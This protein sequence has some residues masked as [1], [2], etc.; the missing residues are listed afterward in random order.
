[1]RNSITRVLSAVLACVLTLNLLPAGAVDMSDLSLPERQSQ[2]GEAASIAETNVETPPLETGILQIATSETEPATSGVT[3]PTGNITWNIDTE[4]KTFTLTGSGPMTDFGYGSANYKDVPWYDFFYANRY[5]GNKDAYSIVIGEGITEIYDLSC[6]YI[7]DVSFPSTLTTIGDYCF[8][9]LG[10]YAGSPAI[11]LPESVT[12]VGEY[13]FH[14]LANVT[15]ITIPN[16]DAQLGKYCFNNCFDLTELVLPTN[17]TTIPEGMA[18]NCYWMTEI[19]I[20]A[21]VTS[22]GASAFRSCNRLTEAILPEGLVELGDNAFTSCYSLTNV[23]QLPDTL[24]TIGRAAFGSCAALTSVGDFPDSLKTIGDSAF[25]GCTALTHFNF[26]PAMADGGS[27]GERAFYQ[28]SSLSGHLTVPDG[29]TLGFGAFSYCPKITGVTLPG[30][31]DLLSPGYSDSG[32]LGVFNSCSGITQVTI[33]DSWTYVPERLFRSCGN[34]SQVTLPEGL[35]E[36][37]EYAFGST[38]LTELDLPSTLVKIGQSAFGGTLITQLVIPEGVTHLGDSAFGGCKQLREITLPSTLL[39]LTTRQADVA[40]GAGSAFASCTALTDVHLPENTTRIP[41]NFFS[42]CT[43][44]TGLDLPDGLL[45]I[46]SGAFQKCTAM[47]SFT[48]PPNVEEVRPGAFTGSG[49]TYLR[50]LGDAPY[51]P[52][53]NVS[54]PILSDGV[55]IYYTPGREGWTTPE[56]ESERRYSSDYNTITYLAYP[57]MGSEEADFHDQDYLSKI[58]LYHFTFQSPEGLLDQVTLAVGN[59]SQSSGEASELSLG[60]VLQDEDTLTFSKPGY[61]TA[62][63]PAGLLDSFNTITLTPTTVT[64]PFVQSIYARHGEKD[65]WRNILLD[66]ITFQGGSLS[67]QTQFY[68]DVNWNGGQSG[69]IYLSPT[70]NTGDGWPIQTGFCDADDLSAR[71]IPGSA[72]NVLLVRDGRIVYAAPL[73]VLVKETNQELDIHLGDDVASIPA[74]SPGGNFGELATKFE[75]SYDF[76]DLL[77]FSMSVESDGKVKILLGVKFDQDLT[78]EEFEPFYSSIKD[79]LLYTSGDLKRPELSFES[80]RNLISNRGGEFTVGMVD[81]GIKSEVQIFG[82]AEGKLGRDPM[83]GQTTITFLDSAVAMSVEGK[84]VEKCQLYLSGTPIC[85]SGTLSDKLTTTIPLTNNP[86]AIGSLV[87][88]YRLAKFE[89]DLGLKIRAGFGWEKLLSAGIYGKISGV[90]GG[91]FPVKLDETYLKLSGSV[92]LSMEVFS[93][94]EQDTELFKLPKFYFW[95][96]END[97]RSRT[98][99]SYAEVLMANADFNPVS[100]DYL[101]APADRPMPLAV[102]EENTAVTKTPVFLNVLPSANAQVASFSDGRQIAVWTHDPGTDVRPEANNRTML[103]F[104]SRAS[105]EDPWSEPTPVLA[106]DDGTADFNPVLK[107]VYDTL[108]VLWQNASRPLTAQDDINTIP[109]LLDISCAKIYRSEN[110]FTFLATVG[111]ENYDTTYDL[112]YFNGSYQVV[113]ASCSDNTLHGG[114]GTYSIHRQYPS[115][116]STA[117]TLASGLNAVDGLCADTGENVWYS[118]D[119]DPNSNELSDYTVFHLAN[120]VSTP[121]ARGGA[122]KPTLANNTLTWYQDGAIRCGDKVIPLAEDTDRY[123]YLISQTGMRAVVYSSDDEMRRS[124]LW[125]SFDDGTG[126]GTPIPV[127]ELA[128]NI[129]GLSAFFDSNGGLNILVCERGLDDTQSNYLSGIADLNLYTITPYCDLTVTGADYLSHS[130][131]KGGQLDLMADVVN[132]GMAAVQTLT[133]QVNNGDELLSSATYLASLSTGQSGQY[134]ISIPL[135][136]P[137]SLTDLSVTVTALGYDEATPQDNTAPVVLRLQDISVEG[138]Q[139]TRAG[140]KSTLRTMVVNRGMDTLTELTATL[141]DADGTVLAQRPISDCTPGEGE[142]V[143][144]EVDVPD[145]DQILTIQVHSAALAA[146]AENLIGNN[147]AVFHVAGNASLKPPIKLTAGA[148]KTA[149]N[150]VNV[151][152]LVDAPNDAVTHVYAAGYDTQGRMVDMSMVDGSFQSIPL[153][154][155]DIVTVKVFG[156]DNR[157]VPITDVQDIPVKS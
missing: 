102:E 147:S 118:T 148:E 130:L 87:P 128:G 54:G 139:V 105:D 155:A 117:L 19:E 3:G 138:S 60:L 5:G 132:S 142:F 36:I 17:L 74:Q 103:Y 96:E 2:T 66:P 113:W 82:Y 1:M 131:V 33:P 52:Y 106:E 80:I 134:Y 114:P 42:N 47:T 34:L 72:L 23:G 145:E 71:L 153:S 32:D 81:L 28:C 94:L 97:A 70:L 10:S 133:I 25:S 27:I 40:G 77:P 16:P 53:T 92:G 109:G 14:N 68:L 39:A 20:P 9:G 50:F 144:F 63:L 136:D 141:M 121:V 88:A 124:T 49:L 56:W 99:V 115:S 91:Y 95:G 83:T 127:K 61:H 104:S 151:S 110:S 90:L 135:D 4:T 89:N 44:L 98:M 78:P 107:V 157:L 41:V 64:T 143:S 75:F 125:A 93:V 62:A 48:V 30:D 146:D 84:L 6:E 73:N 7:R 22:I 45:Y 46:D 111:T 156:L 18:L 122:T 31:P 101:G 79:R 51:I 126:W 12:Y 100:R 116:T 76:L 37:E 24:T 149:P 43:A 86:E 123:T 13:A 108:Y 11:V 112:G 152:V 85:I 69:G 55:P 8:G 29:V 67:E 120:G 15:S 58:P 119:T 57:V 21:G 129:S 154:G 59:E 137:A 26:T 38:D 65:D 150:V 35:T 140:E